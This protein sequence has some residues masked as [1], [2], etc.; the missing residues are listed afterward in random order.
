MRTSYKNAA[1]LSFTGRKTYLPMNDSRL[2][3][4]KFSAGNDCVYHLK[5]PGHDNMKRAEKF[6]ITILH[7]CQYV[8][9]YV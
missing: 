5:I 8:R 7:Y 6:G 9:L 3:E 1:F 2:Q 4:V